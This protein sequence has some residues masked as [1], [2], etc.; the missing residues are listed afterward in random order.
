[1]SFLKNTYFLFAFLILYISRVGDVLAL[2]CDPSPEIKCVS[3]ASNGDVT[4]TW[5]NPNPQL[6]FNKYYIF[7]SKNKSGPYLA[8]DSIFNIATTTYTHTGA[9]AN[10]GQVFYYI[11]GNCGGS[12]NAPAIDTISTLFLKINNPGNGTAQLQWNDIHTPA[13][14]SSFG[15]YRVYR[16]YPTGTWTLVDSTKNL[17]YIDTISVCRAQI[18]YR[19]EIGDNT[20][21]NSVS[22]AAGGIFMDLIV[23]KIPFLDSVTVNAAGKAD[24]GWEPSKSG[25]TQGYVVYQLINGIWK[26]IDT[27]I[28][29]NNT[30]YTNPNSNANSTIETYRVA[31]FDSCGK[32]LSPMG[33]PHNTILVTS[34]PNPCMRI[35]VLNWNAYNYMPTG[36]KEYDV[37]VST[38]G[39]P[40][41]LLGTTSATTTTF[42]HTN[43][44]QTF[45]YCY[46]VVAKDISGQHSSSSN[47]YCYTANI[48]PQPTFSYLKSA[49]V[50]ASNTVNVN[51]YVDVAAQIKKYKVLRSESPTGPF[52]L[53]GAIPFNASAMVSY[54]DKTAKTSEKSYYYKTVAVDTCNNDTTV[55]NLGRT[56]LLTAEANDNRTNT[57]TWNDY[58]LW[59]GSVN[60]YNVYRSIDGG[61]WTGPIA[62]I[63][64]T[65]AGVNTFVDDVSNYYPGQGIFSYYVMALEDAGNPYGIQDSSKSNVAEALQDAKVFIPNAFVPTGKNK[66]FIPVMTYTDKTEYVFRIFDRWGELV[67]ETNDPYQAWDGTSNGKKCDENIYA[68]T[69]QFKTAYGQYVERKGI[70]TLLR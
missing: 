8:I 58:E 37:Y 51:C 10:G 5:K 42:T 34:N 23:P 2:P 65:A 29:I 40:Y 12:Q 24:I 19:I 35:N 25:D 36:V 55:T 38:N 32:H 7:S 54:T 9:A 44:Q 26:S 49:T 16:E 30:F 22:S 20:G 61:A 66:L 21:C 33:N 17:S 39:S 11:I 62:N 31:A 57:L 4:I 47:K 64:Y 6:N 56:I 1:M 69:L 67:F 63:P 59:L 50:V 53:I 45:V 15:W 43:T 46:V 13:I 28:G 14:S 68:Y 18:N 70:V 3:V 48:P 52:T 27:I 60:S 41:V